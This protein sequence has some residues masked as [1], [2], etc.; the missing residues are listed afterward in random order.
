[1]EL[2]TIEDINLINES[3]Y[4]IVLPGTEPEIKAGDTVVKDDIK[5]DVVISVN[6]ITHKEA[7]LKKQIIQGGINGNKIDWR[8]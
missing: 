3:L 2:K 7:F 1:M 4:R 6:W 8:C 5:Y